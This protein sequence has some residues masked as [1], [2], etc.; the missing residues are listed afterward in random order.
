[1]K[2]KILP[3]RGRPE[4]APCLKS[5][6]LERDLSDEIKA[7]F[8]PLKRHACGAK[9]RYHSPPLPPG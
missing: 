9:H 2:P 1:M 3:R 4:K 8:P 7:N 5:E 6:R